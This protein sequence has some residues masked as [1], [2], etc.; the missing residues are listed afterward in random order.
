MKASARNTLPLAL[1]VGLAAGMLSVASAPVGARAEP[2]QASQSNATPST[3]IEEDVRL[4]PWAP[5]LPSWARSVRIVKGDQPLKVSPNGNADRRGSGARQARLPLYGARPGPGCGGPWLHVGPQA[6]VCS[7]E[8]ALSGGAP[9]LPT[10]KLLTASTDGLPFRYFFASRDGSLG[11]GRLDEVDIGVPVTTLEP[12][13]AVAIVEQRNIGRETFGRT[14]RGVWVPMRDFHAARPFHFEG[15][16]LDGTG[17]TI[18]HAWVMKD[19]TPLYARRGQRFTPTGKTKDRFDRVGWLEEASVFGSSWARIDETHWI[20][21]KDVRHPTVA[22]PPDEAEIAHGARW[23]DIELESQTLVAYEGAKP[24]F[25]TLVST[26]K[27]KTK[28]HPFETP[29][30]VHRIWVKLLATTM[31][32]LEDEYA[33]RYWRIEDVPYVQFF[34]KGVGLHAAFWHRSFGNVRSHGCVNLAPRDAQRLFAFTSPRIGAGWTAALP[35][36][37]DQGTI[38]RVR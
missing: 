7:D 16:A 1:T 38:V 21:Q 36:A 29:K 31:D 37:Y 12:G 26:G 22:P 25:A 17:D 3:S 10:A 24:V 28:G 27:G 18:P 8:V 5:T 30:G 20:R 6:W 11:Y 19:R 23:I 13:F 2:G 35:T 9:L 34:H 33:N 32:N 15:V 14:N 4:P